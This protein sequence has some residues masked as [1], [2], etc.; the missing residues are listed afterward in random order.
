MLGFAQEK[1]GLSTVRSEKRVWKEAV[2]CRVAFMHFSD[3]RKTWY[4]H[5]VR[6]LPCLTDDAICKVFCYDMG[7]KYPLPGCVLS[8]SSSS[9]TCFVCY[10]RYKRTLLLL[11]FGNWTN[12]NVFCCENKTFNILI[13][14]LVT[15]KSDQGRWGV[16]ATAPGFL[17]NKAS[18]A[19]R[20]PFIYPIPRV[21]PAL[22]GNMA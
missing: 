19:I 8:R 2:A 12:N 6:W 5:T 16:T 21:V 22:K 10:S 18:Q 1:G 7:T 17:W 14:I 9:L 20:S 15:M 13:Q 11:E 4:P 3:D